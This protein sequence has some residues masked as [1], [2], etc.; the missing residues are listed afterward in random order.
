MNSAENTNIMSTKSIGH[1]LRA[2]ACAI[3]ASLA[4]TLAVQ[5][6]IVETTGGSVIK[7][8][9]VSADDGAIKIETDFAGVVT[10]KQDQVKSIVTDGPVFVALADGS[11]QLGRIA[12]AGGGL[13]VSSASGTVATTAAGVTNIW[14]QGAKSPADRA[15]DAL[16]RTWVYE[17]A[18]DLNGRQ[19]NKDRLFFGLSGRATLAGPD[20]RLVFFGN[21]S[22][23]EENSV[24]SQDEAK[25][26]VDYTNLFS[27]RFSWYA[28]T[29]LGYDKIKDLDLRS[30]TAFGFGYSMIKKPNQTLDARGGVS[31][32]FES[33]PTGED[34]IDRDFD[35]A[36][37]DLG[38]LH[39]CT[40]SFGK[41]IN[42][43]T[44][45]P[46]F[47]DFGNYVL[48]HESVLELP[49]SGKRDIRLRMGL[50]NDY[51]SQ[52]PPGLKSHDW[53][54]FSSLVFVWK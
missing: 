13:A 16:R 7:G 38:L 49:F 20:D 51:T 11:T 33:Y 46:A 34:G 53:S 2:I 27:P 39:T 6:D 41:M 21:F 22:Q 29:E 44:F 54:Y 26:G 18:F 43:V 1:S 45:T 3:G 19:G 37:L 32:R 30:Q 14:L 42:T 15:A 36:G 35:A 4:A 17:A 9:I 48:N 8:K 5:A 40:F 47:S 25:V 31:Y 10:I 23:A 28:R 50:K 24:D 12:A 52:P